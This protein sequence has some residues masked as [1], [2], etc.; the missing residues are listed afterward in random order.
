MGV[1]DRPQVE[2]YTPQFISEPGQKIRF[3]IPLY[4]RLFTW[5]EKNIQDLLEDLLSHFNNPKTSSLPYYLGI[6]TQIYETQIYEERKSNDGYLV[7]LDGQQRITVLMLLAAYFSQYYDNWKSF[8]FQDNGYELNRPAEAGNNAGPREAHA[9]LLRL[10][11]F[12]RDEDRARLIQLIYPPQKALENQEKTLLEEGYETIAKFISTHFPDDKENE[13]KE[14]SENIFKRLTL[15]VTN[16]KS[17]YL[18][19]PEYLNRYFEIMNS[20]YKN[21]EQH[22]VLKVQLATGASNAREL[23]SLWEICE[24]FSEDVVEILKKRQK[25]DKSDD[26]ITNDVTSIA[27]ELKKSAALPEANATTRDGPTHNSNAHSAKKEKIAD[28]VKAY[29]NPASKAKPGGRSIINFPQF[30]LLA[31][32]IFL[33]MENP[34]PEAKPATYYE[35]A[36]LLE[37]FKSG[38][39]RF[40][41]DRLEEFYTFLLRL[42]VLLDMYVIRRKDD[43][44]ESYSVLM[45]KLKEEDRKKETVW[46]PKNPRCRLAQYQAMLDAAFP[47]SFYTWLKP[48]LLDLYKYHFINTDGFPAGADEAAAFLLRK[49]KAWDNQRVLTGDE[50]HERKSLS[51]L[52]EPASL[53]YG[54]IDRYWFWRLDY[55]LWEGC[56][57][58]TKELF[59][60]DHLKAVRAY[61]MRTNRS[62]EHLFPQTAPPGENPWKDSD[63]LHSFGNLAM[64]SRSFNSQQSNERVGVKFGRVK[65]HI[66]RSELQS[67]K[68]LAMYQAANRDGSNWTQT[69]AKEH[70]SRMIKI[71]LDSFNGEPGAG[72][73]ETNASSLPA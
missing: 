36:K 32:D 13:R 26:S 65:D 33:E 35:T 17:S 14:F 25:K 31:L 7:V 24:N 50:H 15:L 43:S 19:N 8:L 57:D 22:E 30:L 41:P 47:E 2:I 61:R 40:I 38:S 54:K 66:D 49:L 44:E 28:I 73:G 64:I 62:I 5:K 21:L 16:L 27:A 63:A 6:I 68:L 45:G 58:S 48:Y 1:S 37:T 10:W 70:E 59:G 71:L 52:L 34:S 29:Y 72:H 20:N 11:P 9:G 4:Q 67:L 42:R 56:E 51:A 53:T 18:D 3:K 23:F 39:R 60:R 12:A 55:Y 69:T 46:E